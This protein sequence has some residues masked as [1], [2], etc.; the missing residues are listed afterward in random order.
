M[1][2][3]KIKRARKEDTRFNSDPTLPE[4]TTTKPVVVVNVARGTYVITTPDR[5]E[6]VRSRYDYLTNF[7][8]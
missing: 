8:E 1:A 4:I 3:R 7:K 5:V 6:K 2:A